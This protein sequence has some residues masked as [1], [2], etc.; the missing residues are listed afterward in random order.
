MYEFWA[1]FFLALLFIIVYFVGSNQNRKLNIKYAKAIREYMTLHSEFVG[2]RAYGHSGFR[3]L[4]RLKKEKAFSRI[5]M[6]VALVDRENLMHY[7]LSLITKEHDRLVCWGHLKNAAPMRL[8]L[9]PTCQEK[10]RK[11]FLSDPSIKEAP[12][13]ISAIKDFSVFSSDTDL[14]NRFLS[15][16]KV[17]K[18]F[19]K[20]KGFVKSLSIDR[21]NSLV[22]LIY[23]LKRESLEPAFEFL[24]TCGETL[25]RMTKRAS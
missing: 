23:D 14:A 5:E 4:C 8:E 17:Q 12:P 22:H 25:A 9:F 2:F 19:S 18:N 21:E 3:S 11:K 15:N 6:A 13:R 7:P 20:T 1:I 16:A 10:L 24:M